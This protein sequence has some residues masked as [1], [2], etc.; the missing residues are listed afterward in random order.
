L[1]TALVKSARF[2]VAT[3][4]CEESPAIL[5]D[6]AEL[7]FYLS[8]LYLHA[9]EKALAI[10]SYERALAL[11]PVLLTAQQ[12]LSRLLLDTEQLEQAEALCR[13]E[14][15]L[16]TERFRP[17]HQL[18]VVLHRMARHTELIEQFNRAISLNPESAA[19]Y[20]CLGGAY[21]DINDTEKSLAL[22]Q[23]NLERAVALEPRSSGFHCAL[24]FSYWRGAQLDR[25]MASYDRAI[26]LNPDDVMARWARVM[27]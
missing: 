14:I 26:E 5:P 15:E 6:S 10:A 13:R 4:L 12:T 9:D 8:N 19:S 17:Y 22:S 24:G 27:L 11:N 7:H 1:I 25:A 20:F 2:A 23:A 21:A 16:T 18:G 3:E